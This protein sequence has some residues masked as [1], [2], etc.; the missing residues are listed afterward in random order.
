MAKEVFEILAEAAKKVLDLDFILLQE[1]AANTADWFCEHF[2]TS[3]Y[4]WWTK[5][6]TA[7]GIK[8]EWEHRVCDSTT[9]RSITAVAL[10]ATED[11]PATVLV[12]AHAPHQT[13]C[14]NKDQ[15]EYELFFSELAATMEKFRKNK[16]VSKEQ[17]TVMGIDANCEIFAQ[18]SPTK[19]AAH[20][21]TGTKP[22]QRSDT[23]ESFFANNTLKFSNTHWS[24]KSNPTRNKAEL[25]TH[26]GPTGSRRQIDFAGITKN[27]KVVAYACQKTKEAF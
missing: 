2:Q 22:G 10:K 11:L 3:G 19:G 6:D 17:Q 15:Q 7:V 5:G 18:A 8:R 4:I 16:E 1:T 24:R 26:I 14:K 23:V 20:Y 21:N 12:S 25:F 27:T 13:S 9:T